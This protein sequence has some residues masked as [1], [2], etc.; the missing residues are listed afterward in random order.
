MHWST[1]TCLLVRLHICWDPASERPEEQKSSVLRWQLLRE[2]LLV[3][4]CI[5]FSMET[6]SKLNF[7]KFSNIDAILI[8]DYNVSWEAS[9]QTP[10]EQKLRTNKFDFLKNLNV[11][12]CF[13][14]FVWT[15]LAFIGK[16]F[17]SHKSKNYFAIY[18]NNCQFPNYWNYLPSLNFDNFTLLF[19]RGQP[20]NVQSFT[21]HVL[22]YCSAH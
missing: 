4:W 18:L 17:S 2:Y 8:S 21:T 13:W 15:W 5:H 12:C 7:Q 9:S 11:N 1:W 6:S 16:N 10:A 3:K 19:C 20:R 22:S 14:C